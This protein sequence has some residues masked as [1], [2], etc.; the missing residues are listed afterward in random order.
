[1]MDRIDGKFHAVK[2]EGDD[3]TVLKF[4]PWFWLSLS[5]ISTT[6]PII[7]ARGI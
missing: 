6:I 3:L 2:R 5:L 4:W 7:M 1:M